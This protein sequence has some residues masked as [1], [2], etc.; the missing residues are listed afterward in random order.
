M[1]PM[2]STALARSFS[3]QLADLRQG[4]LESWHAEA[5]EAG[6]VEWAAF[7]SGTRLET[8]TKPLAVAKIPVQRRAEAPILAAG[9][10]PLPFPATA[11]DAAGPRLG[12]MRRPATPAPGPPCP[13]PVVFPPAELL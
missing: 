2:T 12:R 9:G 4:I 3:A 8:G 1:V 5:P 13:Q 7:R 10:F 11:A 6:L